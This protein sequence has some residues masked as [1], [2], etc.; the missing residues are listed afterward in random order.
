MN[1]FNAEVAYARMEQNIKSNQHRIDELEKQSTVTQKILITLERIVTEM[2]EMKSAIT[3]TSD[4]IK[5]F[6]NK[7]RITVDLIKATAVSAIVSGLVTAYIVTI[8]TK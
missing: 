1:E 2:R 8:I 7:P 4:R 3:D 6:E 5:V